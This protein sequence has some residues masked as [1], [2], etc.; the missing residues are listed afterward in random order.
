MCEVMEMDKQYFLNKL[1][2]NRPSVFETYG[3]D[4]LP[5]TFLATD[6]IPIKCYNH[7]IFYQRVYTH[8]YG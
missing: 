4:L 5:D 7:G 2:S 6:K 3:Y 1:N 8:I